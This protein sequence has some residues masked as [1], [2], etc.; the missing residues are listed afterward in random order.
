MALT[1]KWGS[2]ISSIRY[3]IRSEGSAI[4]TRITAGRTVHTISIS[5]ES[6]IYMLVSLV[7]TIATIMYSTR[8]L[9]RNTI[10]SAWSWKWSISSITGEAASWKPS[11]EGCAIKFQDTQGSNLQLCL[12]KAV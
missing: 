4:R 1:V 6:K 3:R 7:D 10:I 9:I 8:V 2:L 11:C 5:C 12:D